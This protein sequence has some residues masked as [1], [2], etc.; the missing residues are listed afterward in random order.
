MVI[1]LYI[2]DAGDV[3]YLRAHE[4]EIFSTFIL[5]RAIILFITKAIYIKPVRAKKHQ[6][7]KACHLEEEM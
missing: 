7:R 2:F 6:E 3:Q 4:L 1:W 5:L